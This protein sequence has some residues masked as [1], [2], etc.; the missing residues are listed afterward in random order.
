MNPGS[1]LAPSFMPH[2]HC[3]LWQPEMIAVQVTS[4]GLIA[5]AYLAISLTL[6]RL[7]RRVPGLPFPQVY[8][9]FG[10]FIVTCGVTHLLDVWTVWQPVYWLD[11]AVRAL[12]AIASVGTAIMIV[13]LVP[14]AVTLAGTARAPTR[15]A[16][17]ICL[18][19]YDCTGKAILRASRGTAAR[20]R[21]T[22][23]KL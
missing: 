14:A 21:H 8:V 19:P 17:C 9:A 23:K 20:V 2:G 15:T 13:P 10:A 6:L 7:V 4:N 5:A 3:W 11:A 1:S 12:T 22:R 16:R 18:L